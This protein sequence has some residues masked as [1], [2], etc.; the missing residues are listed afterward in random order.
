MLVSFLFASK[1]DVNSN[2]GR[3][4]FERHL[5]SAAFFHSSV[6]IKDGINTARVI[7]ILI[8]RLY[9]FGTSRIDNVRNVIIGEIIDIQKQ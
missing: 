8:C 3:E 9:T 4:F 6:T 7:I 2:F 5:K 1:H